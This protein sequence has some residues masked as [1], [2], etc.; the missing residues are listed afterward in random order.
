MS[1]S[2]SRGRPRDYS[3]VARNRDLLQDSV[4]LA[5]PKLERALSLLREHEP[6]QGWEAQEFV[7]RAIHDLTVGT[8]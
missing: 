8:E 4:D 2:D 7:K 1:Q 3:A 5:V 6:Y